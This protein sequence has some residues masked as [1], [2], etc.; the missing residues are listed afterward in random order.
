[1]TETEEPEKS[2]QTNKAQQPH[3]FLAVGRVLRP[4]GVRGNL[5]ITAESEVIT[6]I[7]P[8]SQI[9][10]GPEYI[11]YTVRHFSSHRGH[12]LLNLET[13]NSRDDAEAYRESTLYIRFEDTSPLP[14]DVYFYW[15]LLGL[16]V[17]SDEDEN[18][19]TLVEIIE[20]GANDVYVVRSAKGEELLLPAIES[21]IQSIDLEKKS[22]IVHLIPGLKSNL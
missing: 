15:Q 22:M 20:T 16:D 12:Y 19:G 17:W 7:T 10:L 21:V 18:L 9:F 13:L 14:E 3:E 4:H 2:H 8:G 11:P 5:L 6:S 1:M